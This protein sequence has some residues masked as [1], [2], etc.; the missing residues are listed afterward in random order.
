MPYRF[1]SIISKC[2]FVCGLTILKLAYTLY[3]S[4]LKQSWR[5][6]P[7]LF[8]RLDDTCAKI[9]CKCDFKDRLPLRTYSILNDLSV[10]NKSKQLTVALVNQSYVFAI[11]GVEKCSVRVIHSRFVALN[12]HALHPHDK[13][14]NDCINTYDIYVT[15]CIYVS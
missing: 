5:M 13:Q 11:I 10:C 15:Y 3:C 6:W 12:V 9:T 2:L 4:S 7:N 14:R 8:I 1:S